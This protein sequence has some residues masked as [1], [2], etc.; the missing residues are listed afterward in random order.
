[1]VYL[2]WLEF[3]MWQALRRPLKA[4]LLVDSPPSSLL[5]NIRAA[6]NINI[7]DLLIY[8]PSIQG[9]ISVMEEQL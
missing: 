9:D 4:L 2:H 3:G 1:M 5:E 7:N 8:F 6:A